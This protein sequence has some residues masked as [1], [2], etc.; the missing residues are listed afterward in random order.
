MIRWLLDTDIVSLWAQGNAAI[1]QRLIAMPSDELAIS[2]VTAEELLG[3]WY[4]DLRKASTDDRLLWTYSSL[5]TTLA[6]L[7]R[8]TVI[9]FDA[10]ALQL[11]QKYRS[12]KIRVGTN[13][14]RIAATASSRNLI[15]VTRNV[16]DFGL[17][18]GLTLNVCDERQF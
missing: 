15:L 17:I 14:L 2:I 13:D 7:R 5:E 6:F 18:P 4:A 16:S 10:A 9:S 1:C 3:G 11:A 12:Q 8:I